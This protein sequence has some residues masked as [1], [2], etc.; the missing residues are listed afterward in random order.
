M[1]D[2]VEEATSPWQGTLMVEEPAGRAIRS[3]RG[4]DD[5]RP[6]SFIDA[7]RALEIPFK[8]VAVSP[9]VTALIFMCLR[10]P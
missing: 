1:A 3:D 5:R 4:V 2:V 6:D 9:G 8:S 10:S 7:S